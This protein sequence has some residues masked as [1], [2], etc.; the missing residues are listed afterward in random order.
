ML[1]PSVRSR[2][3]LLL[4]V[5]ACC[6]IPRVMQLSQRSSLELPEPWATALT[7]EDN[8]P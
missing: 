3:L 1:S 7:G 4:V 5:V 2:W 6:A 8:H